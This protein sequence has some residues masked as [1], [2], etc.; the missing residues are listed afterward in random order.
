MSFTSRSLVE[1]ARSLGDLQDTKF[2]SYTDELTLINESYRDIYS[3]YTESQGDYWVNESVITLT[4]AMLDPNSNGQGYFVPLPTDFYKLRSVSWQMGSAWAPMDTFSMSNRDRVGGTPQYRIKNGILWV[5]GQTVSQ[6]KI[7]YYPP[8][9]VVTMPDV[10]L[11]LAQNELAFNIENIGSSFY[12]ASDNVYFY[13]FNSKTIK[14]ENRNTG[15]TA[16]LFV[17]TNNIDSLFYN[18]G[19]VYWRDTVAQSI[20]RAF[21]DFTTTLI[22]VILLASTA[23]NM[24]V[25]SPFIYYST[26]TNTFRTSLAGVG[27]TLMVAALTVGFQLI[28]NVQAYTNNSTLIVYNSVVSAINATLISQDGTYLYARQAGSNTLIRIA[29]NTVTNALTVLDTIASNYLSIGSAISGTYIPIVNTQAIATSVP[30]D[31]SF[32]FPVNEV[33]EIMAYQCAINFVRKQ[34]DQ[35]KLPELKDR[36]FG[37]DGLWQRFWS[38]NKRDEYKFVRI[39]NDYQK[40]GNLWGW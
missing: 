35:V 1:Y 20:N 40:T 16:I 30:I 19:W 23:V 10:P 34:S 8:P 25:Q 32:S 18:A 13:V 17:S 11:A 3:R 28:N 39:N 36:L 6:I 2:I 37:A 29:I 38:V 26:L 33:N 4:G 9:V 14:C 7:D 22:P 31:Y 15:T 21:T 24:V 12:S 5:I 27:A